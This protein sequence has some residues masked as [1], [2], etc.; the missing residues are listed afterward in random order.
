MLF[1]LFICV[2]ININYILYTHVCLNDTCDMH[3]K[4]FRRILCSASGR[5]NGASAASSINWQPGDVSDTG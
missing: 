3:V 1:E 2:Y 5:C 4:P